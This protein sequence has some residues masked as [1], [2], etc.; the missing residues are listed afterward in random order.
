VNITTNIK[1]QLALS[2]TE[3]RALELGFL[4]SRPL[5]D[6]RYDLIID[7]HDR[8]LR[9]QVKYANGK[10]THSDGSVRVK[11]EYIS[12]T[13]NVYTYH[14]GE[15]DGLIVYIPRIDKLCFFPPEVYIGKTHLCIRIM[16]SKNN[17]TKGVLLAENYL[18]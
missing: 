10:I 6:A 16:P 4:P 18:W 13:K 8:L 12:R 9:L 11:L 3:L 14:Q 15:I 7:T 2:K 5:F 1:G 17:Q